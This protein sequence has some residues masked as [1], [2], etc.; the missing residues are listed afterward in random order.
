MDE[1]YERGGGLRDERRKTRKSRGCG[2]A[3]EAE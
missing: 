2:K 1:G 3:E